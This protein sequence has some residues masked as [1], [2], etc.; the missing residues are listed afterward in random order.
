M[1]SLKSKIKRRNAAEK[2]VHLPPCTDCSLSDHCGVNGVSC[3]G[4]R[5]FVSSE[6]SSYNLAVAKSLVGLKFKGE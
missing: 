5:Y 3:W 4:Y 2:T 1:H 6:E